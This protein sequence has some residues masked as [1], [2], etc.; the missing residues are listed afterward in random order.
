V[1]LVRYLTVWL[2][3]ESSASH[4]PISSFIF[5]DILL[6][7]PVDSEI[8]HE[9]LRQALLLPWEQAASIKAVLALL[10]WWIFQAPRRRPAFLQEDLHEVLG[11]DATEPTEDVLIEL[12]VDRYIRRIASLFDGRPSFGAES[13][14]FECYREAV[15]FMRGIGLGLHFRVSPKLWHSLITTAL[16]IIKSH[17]PASGRCDQVIGGAG[18]AQVFASLIV[19]TLV[20]FLVRSGTTERAHWE[21]VCQVLRQAT[22][23]APVVTEWSRTAAALTGLFLEGAALAEDSRPVRRPPA[24]LPKYYRIASVEDLTAVLLDEPALP[25]TGDAEDPFLDWR[26]LAR[27][28]IAFL[29]RNWLRVLGDLCAIDVPGNHEL[30]V[31][32]LASILERLCEVHDGQPCSSTAAPPPLFEFVEALLDACDATA[33]GFE[34]SRCVAIAALARLLCRCPDVALPSTLL[35][36]FYLALLNGMA[37]KDSPVALVVLRASSHVFAFGL[38]GSTLLIPSYLR[39]I[40][41]ILNAPLASPDVFVAILRLVTSIALLPDIFPALLAPRVEA[42]LPIMSGMPVVMAGEVRLEDVRAQAQYLVA[43]TAN[44]LRD[45]PLASDA[46]PLIPSQLV[47]STFV[48]LLNELVAAPGSD[49]ALVEK[50]LG[51]LLHCMDQQARPSVSLLSAIEGLTQ[52][53]PLGIFSERIQ[54]ALTRSLIALLSRLLDSRHPDPEDVVPVVHALLGWAMALPSGWLLANEDVCRAL[55]EGLF[56]VL[57]SGGPIADAGKHMLSHLMAHTEHCCPLEPPAGDQANATRHV[58]YGLGSAALLCVEEIGVTESTGLVRV[59]SRTPAG[60][61]TWDFEAFYDGTT[62]PEPVAAWSLDGIAGQLSLGPAVLVE[63]LEPYLPAEQA[64]RPSARTAS[65]RPRHQAPRFSEATS[66]EATD[67]LAELLAYLEEDFPEMEDPKAAGAE[68]VPPGAREEVARIEEQ[69]RA[70]VEAERSLSMGYSAALSPSAT[71]E[72]P[73]RHRTAMP[74]PFAS[75]PTPFQYCRQLVLQ[76]GLLGL[77][78]AGRFPAKV[79]SPSAAL[80]RELR[81]L[82]ARG[83]PRETAKIGLIYVAPGCETEEAI[84]G[85]QEASESYCDFCR[86]LGSYV[87]LSAH[88]GFTGGLEPGMTVDGRALYYA[89]TLLEAVFHE[90][91]RMAPPAADDAQPLLAKKRHVGNDPVHIVWNEH[92]RPYRPSTIPGDFGN[93]QIV[94]TPKP[95]LGLYAVNI[96]ADEHFPTAKMGIGP[97]FDGSLVPRALLATLVRATAISADRLI[98]LEA[99][100]GVT[101]AL[102]RKACLQSIISKYGCSQWGIEKVLSHAAQGE[103]CANAGVSANASEPIAQSVAVGAE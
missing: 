4:H 79:L 88:K 101:P 32:T 48:L 90:P 1:I 86:A 72:T 43:L 34:Q 3:P 15:S 63:A 73:F 74:A 2:L 87:T 21:G 36:R 50:Y 8:V 13:G 94:V 59:T 60:R 70:L 99:S 38:P 82:D 26:A 85:C 56:G 46:D 98:A 62:R 102:D 65:T 54:L 51:L 25:D 22:R 93:Y 58:Y 80:Q 53:F 77:D 27:P 9:I 89:T 100:G 42:P 24:M 64:A 69:C 10:K 30:A 31:R 29:W 47:C 76:C 23:W 91:T 84:L 20:G 33:K 49:E 37:D 19:E 66:L 68:F 96:Y 39:C 55:F 95:E 52:A 41:S 14:Q 78:D 16:S 67:M 40:A 75:A 83:G 28:A 7:S 61:F 81:A 5:V 44:H 57:Q 35:A 11:E 103:P 12:Y 6:S 17:L 97:L 71:K 45:A 92:W 18:N